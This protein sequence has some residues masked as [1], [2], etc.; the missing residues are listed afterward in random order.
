LGLLQVEQGALAL[1]LAESLFLGEL[2]LGLGTPVAAEVD[3]ANAPLRQNATD[4]Q[5]AM[6]VGGVFFPTHQ[7]RAVV[8]DGA[9]DPFDP[10]LKRRRLS[11][12]IVAHVALVVVELFVVG[13]AAKEISEKPVLDS[14]AAKVAAD[15]LAIE[16]R[17]VA[18]VGTRAH[19]DDERDLV[20]LDDRQELVGRMIRMPDGE[21]R[22]V[23][24]G[25]RRFHQWLV[26]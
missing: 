14:P 7:R 12:P 1:G 13:P 24:V 17:R 26:G 21:D 6:T 22:H 19:V 16:M 3:Y 11:E 20:L 4:Q 25:P 10:P 18:G 5:P 8:F 9:E 2:L 15:G 23:P